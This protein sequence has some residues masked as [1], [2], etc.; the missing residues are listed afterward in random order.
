MF[1][2]GITIKVVVLPVQNEFSWAVVRLV[3]LEARRGNSAGGGA[4]LV[5]CGGN[6]WVRFW[7]SSRS[8]LL[9]EFVAHQHGMTCVLCLLACLFVCSVVQLEVGVHQH[10][11]RAEL[12][13]IM[14]WA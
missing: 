13:I 4:N 3:Y 2:I 9:A 10:R 1:W 7:N 6:G 12:P 11:M 8:T 5:S 14:H